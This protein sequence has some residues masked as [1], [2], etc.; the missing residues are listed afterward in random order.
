MFLYWN[1]IDFFLKNPNPNLSSK[2]FHETLLDSNEQTNKTKKRE[3]NP[4]NKYNK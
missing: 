2:S 1:R 4:E 3:E